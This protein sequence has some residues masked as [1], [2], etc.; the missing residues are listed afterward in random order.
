MSFRH[1]LISEF[2]YFR[3][4]IKFRPSY[5]KSQLLFHKKIFIKRFKF[6]TYYYYDVKL[7]TYIYKT[8]RRKAKSGI[9][10]LIWRRHNFYLIKKYFFMI[11][12]EK[13]VCFS[14]ESH[15]C[16]LFYFNFITQ[17]L[18]C[19]FLFLS[20]KSTMPREENLTLN[21]NRYEFFQLI[22]PILYEKLWTPGAKLKYSHYF[23]YYRFY[24]NIFD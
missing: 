17:L 2:S 6:Y 22:L 13:F 15:L 7:L 3:I 18:F 8:N 11:R 1:L 14:F 9:S 23:K 19:K 5:N 20:F 12:N 4:E 16:C 10:K 24:L 21:K